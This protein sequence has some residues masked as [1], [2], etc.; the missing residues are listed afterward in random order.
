MRKGFGPK[1]IL[2][3]PEKLRDEEVFK[4]VENNPLTECVFGVFAKA[5]GV[6]AK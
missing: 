3:V 2:S 5:V 4:A 6:N 1:L